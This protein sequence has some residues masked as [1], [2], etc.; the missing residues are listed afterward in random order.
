[1]ILARLGYR[2]VLE[3]SRVL[4]QCANDEGSKKKFFIDVETGK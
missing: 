3:I 2:Q 1:M 4:S